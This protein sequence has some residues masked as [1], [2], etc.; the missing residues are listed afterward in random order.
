MERE[1]FDLAKQQATICRVFGNPT[2]VLILWIL[3]QREHSVSE[4]ATAVEASLQST[5]HH[6]HVMQ[7]HGILTSRREGNNIYYR[8]WPDGLPSNCGLLH[9]AHDMLTKKE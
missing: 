4:V 3:A 6:L 8:V 9:M 2:R 1:V 7:S 5:S